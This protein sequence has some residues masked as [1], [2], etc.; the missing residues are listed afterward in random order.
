MQNHEQ[1]AT[2]SP[3]MYVKLGEGGKWEKQC[4]E[5]GIIRFGYTETSEKALDGDWDGVRD[6][7]SARRKDQGAATRDLRQIRD[8]FEGGDDTVWITFYDR[9]L[10]WCRAKPGPKLHADGE[11]TYREVIHG[12]SKADIKGEP[13]SFERLSG[14]LLKT[15]AYRGTVCRVP[16]S[17]YLIRKINCE[18]SAPL[19]QAIAAR[20]HLAL[21]ILPLIQQ[22]QP[23]DF[24]L[25]VDL[26]FST[27]GWRRLD[28]TGGTLKLVDI[29]LQ[30]PTTNEKAYVQVKSVAKRE[31]IHEQVQYLSNSGGFSRLFFVSHSGSV[32]MPEDYGDNV[33]FIVG[34]KLAQMV[35]NSGLT[36]WVIDKSS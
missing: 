29:V 36:S 3:V 22:L 35:V 9:F 14:R 33:H 2:S 34:N 13:L 30:L 32:D 17:E 21:M 26:L 20:E 16:E 24:E 8:F 12:W 11:G 10:W 15:Q 25:L 5:T 4:T 31:D 19:A 1:I 27:S 23:K 7:W 6:Y 28:A 18:I